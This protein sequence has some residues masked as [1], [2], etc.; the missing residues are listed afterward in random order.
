MTVAEVL[1]M[2]KPW[3]YL[4]QLDLLDGLVK[5]TR[6]ELVAQ[7]Y[8]D[9]EDDDQGELDLVAAEHL[10]GAADEL[11]EARDNLVRNGWQ[12]P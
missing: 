2:V 3:A 10:Q 7:D 8:E 6:D 5:A 9:D 4:D 1:R 12:Y 11:H